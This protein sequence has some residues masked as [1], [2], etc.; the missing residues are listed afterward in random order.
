MDDLYQRL[1]VDNEAYQ[2]LIDAVGRAFNKALNGGFGLIIA[3]IDWL[4]ANVALSYFYWVAGL[5]NVLWRI[6]AVT[7]T[8]LLL[9]LVFGWRR[10]V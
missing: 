2:G 6:A 3:G 7:G 1:V 5:P 10:S 4:S 8:V 9:M